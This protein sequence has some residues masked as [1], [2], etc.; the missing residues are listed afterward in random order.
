[1]DH[2]AHASSVRSSTKKKTLFRKTE[3]DFAVQKTTLLTLEVSSLMILP[4][5]TIIIRGVGTSFLNYNQQHL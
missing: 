4:T 5:P 1:M 2:H 3:T